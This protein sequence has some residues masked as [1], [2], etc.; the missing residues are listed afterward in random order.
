MVIETLSLS[1]YLR[2]SSGDWLTLAWSRRGKGIPRLPAEVGWDS[3]FGFRLGRFSWVRLG[4]PRR[5]DAAWDS[6]RVGRCLR[7]VR[8]KFIFGSWI[9]N[10]VLFCVFRHTG[11][12]CYCCS[13][14]SA[15][16]F[17]PVLGTRGTGAWRL[18][19]W[20]GFWY[21]VVCYF[22]ILWFVILLFCWVQEGMFAIYGCKGTRLNVIFV[23]ANV[24]LF[25]CKIAT[26]VWLCMHAC[27]SFGVVLENAGL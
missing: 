8:T 11:R 22:V 12:L 18:P 3:Y 16:L 4:Q 23:M 17:E 2:L 27:T 20:V 6:R 13:V 26:W 21:F 9:L 1:F 10:S 24:P 5:K 14:S 15:T 19:G 7:Y 25:C